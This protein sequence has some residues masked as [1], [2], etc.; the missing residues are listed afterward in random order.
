MQ[1]CWCSGRMMPVKSAAGVLAPQH[2]AAL[3]QN[4]IASAGCPV[5]HQ[6]CSAALQP[7]GLKESFRCKRCLNPSFPSAALPG[8]SR[9]CCTGTGCIFWRLSVLRDVVPAT[10]GYLAQDATLQLAM[11]L[12]MLP[13]CSRLCAVSS[14][15]SSRS[16]ATAQGQH[17]HSGCMALPRCMAGSVLTATCNL[18]ASFT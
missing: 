16:T 18:P 6:R 12:A 9:Q 1:P 14:A 10:T 11:R 5:C 8:M 13:L 7:E 4:R 2:Q 15:Q 3:L 17:M